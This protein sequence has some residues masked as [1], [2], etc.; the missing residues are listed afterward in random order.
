MCK[1]ILQ[2]EGGGVLGGGPGGQ[3]CFNPPPRDAVAAIKNAGVKAGKT[4]WRIVDG[5]TLGAEGFHFL[6]IAEPINFLQQKLAELDAVTK[7]A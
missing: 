7:D 5:P 1:C 4:M 6:C 3:P 2:E